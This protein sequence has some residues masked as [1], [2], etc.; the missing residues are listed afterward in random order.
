MTAAVKKKLNGVEVGY[1]IPGTSL[2][3]VYR[4][5]YNVK[6]GRWQ[7][8]GTITVTLKNNVEWH[9]R[10]KWDSWYFL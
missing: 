1:G 2:Q 3:L 7:S 8:R 4:L 9:R 6:A 5:K 10:W